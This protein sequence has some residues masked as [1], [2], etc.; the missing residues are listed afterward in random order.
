MAASSVC[1]FVEPSTWQVALPGDGAPRFV[2][3]PVGEPA[4][5][6][7]AAAQLAQLLQERDCLPCSIML[8][9]RSDRLLAA[10]IDTEDTP[11]RQRHQALT[12]RLEEH[13]PVAAEDCIADFIEHDAAT[14]GVCSELAPLQTMVD[15]LEAEDLHVHGIVPKAMLA[16]Q[17]LLA[18]H[19]LPDEALLVWGDA[20]STDIMLLS[21]RRPTDWRHAPGDAHHVLLA[22][23][24][25][26]LHRPQPPEVVLVSSSSAL[27]ERIRDEVDPDVVSL[28][29][30]DPREAASRFAVRIL[31]GT[32]SPWINLRRDHLAPPEPLRRL[33]M[34]L[35]ACAIAAVLLVLV[36]AGA[37][38][39]RGHQY[40]ELATHY[41]TQQAKQ[42]HG[43][44]PGQRVPASVKGRLESEAKKLRT[45]SGIEQ[46]GK[47]EDPPPS[48]LVVLHQVLSR[49]PEDLR[50]RILDLRIDD[51]TVYL[52]GEARDHSSAD[53]LAAALRA[54]NALSVAAPRTR[55]LKQGGVAFTL[56]ATSPGAQSR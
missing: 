23:N 10:R 1:I 6:A 8:A 24:A 30:E 9:L 47:K 53:T 5:H 17:H 16:A 51:G 39:W 50:H 48:A 34:P 21:G 38:V 11:R 52:D 26:L 12:Y 36:V 22:I 41:R 49:L 31:E 25:V 33:R 56:A 35:R 20:S 19:T 3:L 2:D 27:T 43:A 40:A 54:G 45:I 37:L 28:E 13:L 18:T 44:F 32:A 4:D 42:F 55:K 29:V 14:L 46:E 7:S 15:A